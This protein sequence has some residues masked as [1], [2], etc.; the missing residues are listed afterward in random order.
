[1]VTVRGE[2][3]VSVLD[4]KTYEE[5]TRIKVPNGPGMQ[6]FSPDGKYGYVCSSFVPELDVIT[7]AD[8]KI[9]GRVQHESPF[10]P[11]L[12]PTP[13]GRQVRC[14]LTDVRRPPVS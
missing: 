1:W 14:T 10:C 7:V 5:I 9:V 11:T 2:D 12:P 3:Y 6:I 13:D 4:G 8:H